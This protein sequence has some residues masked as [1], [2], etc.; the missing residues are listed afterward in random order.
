MDVLDTPI[1]FG[2]VAPE[3]LGVPVIFIPSCLKELGIKVVSFGIVSIKI[4]LVAVVF[5]E[6]VITIV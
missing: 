1:L 5:P 4:I 3:L 2:N 6:F